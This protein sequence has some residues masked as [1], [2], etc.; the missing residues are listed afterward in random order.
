MEVQTTQPASCS[1][2]STGYPRWVILEQYVKASN[3]MSC[4][5]ADAKTLAAATTSTGHRIHVSLGLANPPA[6]SAVRVEIPD[7]GADH[8]RPRPMIIAAH[9]DSLLIQVN[10]HH[11][12]S[13]VATAVDH[14][15]YNA[16]AAAA[17]PPRPPSLTL[18]PPYNRG[19]LRDRYLDTDA[20]GILRR[21]DNDMVTVAELHMV[22][23][24]NDKKVPEKKAAELFMFRSGEWSVRR[25]RIRPSGNGDGNGDDE[26]EELPQWWSTDVVIPAGD[27]TLCWV[28]L[29]RGILF[30]DVSEESPW[31]QYR[32]LPETPCFG[33]VSNRNL[34]ITAGG[35]VRFVNVFPRCCCGGAGA[36]ECEQSHNA[37][38]IHTWSLR[39]DD[40]AMEWVMDGMVDS[41]ELWSLEAHKGLPCVPLDYPIV[42]MDEPRVI[43]FMLCE[44][45]HVKHGG[46][47]TLWLLI[48]DMRRKTIQSVSRY[49]GEDWLPGRALIPSGVSYYL[50]SHPTCSSNH[51]TSMGRGHTCQMDIEELRDDNSRNLMLQSSREPS[52][53]PSV[54]APEILAVLQEIPS[55]GLCRDD[56][57]KAYSILSHGNGGRFRSLLGL[58][59]NLRKD[60]LLV[61][62]KGSDA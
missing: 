42:S 30:C 26:I 2:S 33:G 10:I 20:T 60:W 29:S 50:N 4:V 56:M 47:E 44:D 37:Y 15:V 3:P 35:E 31:L 48:V 54:Q 41:T 19:P 36:S 39:M 61:E 24:R 46:D 25:P 6:T 18:L 23:V 51:G 32:P 53:E 21:G 55:Y 62:I 13:Y 12:A 27:T 28:D 5:T 57:L 45:H 22:L 16:G 58:P 59:L 9:K 52:L 34:S 49:A 8:M 7:N 40:M 17:D 38:T 43:C 1:S 11:V 14:F